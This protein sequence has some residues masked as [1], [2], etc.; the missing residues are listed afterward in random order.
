MIVIGHIGVQLPPQVAATIQA[1]QQ[2][3][4][5]ESLRNRLR[6]MAE[7]L[8]RLIAEQRIAAA[9]E[10]EASPSGARSSP[11]ARGAS[12]LTPGASPTPSTTD[13]APGLSP[14]RPSAI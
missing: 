12:A 13:T 4:E 14:S 7:A 9:P 11:T 5:R 6:E 3:Q 1:Y 10:R 8:E 2:Q